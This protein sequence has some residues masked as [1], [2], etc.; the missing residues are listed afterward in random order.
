VTSAIINETDETGVFY[1]GGASGTSISAPH[2]SGVIALLFQKNPNLTQEDLRRI[3]LE[4]AS[5]DD[6]TGIVPN[7]YW[8][9]GKVD[10]KA[11]YAALLNL[12]PS[13]GPSA[14]KKASKTMVQ[15]LSGVVTIKTEGSIVITLKVRDGKIEGMSATGP[16]GVHLFVHEI[17]FALGKKEKRDD[18]DECRC[19]ELD[20]SGGGLVCRTCAC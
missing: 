18:N 20:P 8:G 3:L 9:Y 1:Q 13:L 15:Q 10:A 6:F 16:G 7:I 2:V 12:Q 14:K 11:A 19:C 5:T 4:N 17:K